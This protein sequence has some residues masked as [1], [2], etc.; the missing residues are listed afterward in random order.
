[1]QYSRTYRVHMRIYSTDTGTN[2]PGKKVAAM[3]IVTWSRDSSVGIATGYG[4]GR[5]KGWSSSPDGGQ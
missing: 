1:M 4:A 5:P 2:T 3:T